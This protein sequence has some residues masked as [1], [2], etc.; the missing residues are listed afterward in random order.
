MIIHR[1][2]CKVE[3]RENGPFIRQRNHRKTEQR[4]YSYLL[5]LMNTEYD[6]FPR[7]L[8]GRHETN[9]IWERVYSEYC[10]QYDRYRSLLSVEWDALDAALPEEIR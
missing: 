3:V 6:H 9:P 2:S 5:R 7:R 10:N 1:C 4:L 8:D